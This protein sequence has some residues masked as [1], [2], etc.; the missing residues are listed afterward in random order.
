[1]GWKCTRIFYKKLLLEQLGKEAGIPQERSSPKGKDSNGKGERPVRKKTAVGGRR[2]GPQQ[3]E[4]KES[5][6]EVPVK[7]VG[8]KKRA[9]PKSLKRD[10]N[11]LSPGNDFKKIDRTRA[12]SR[13]A[14]EKSCMKLGGNFGKNVLKSGLARGRPSSKAALVTSGHFWEA[15]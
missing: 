11:S 12:R 6:R 3:F 2:E 8:G 4:G 9:D 7:G 5:P 1:L 14:S 10:R 15:G 13:Q